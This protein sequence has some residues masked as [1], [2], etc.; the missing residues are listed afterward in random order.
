MPIPPLA[1]VEATY[2]GR[3]WSINSSCAKF[4]VFLYLAL[5]RMPGR[6]ARLFLPG[7]SWW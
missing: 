4:F 3:D 6:L 2:S 7:R 1:S 5:E